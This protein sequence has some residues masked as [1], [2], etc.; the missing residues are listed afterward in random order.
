MVV[1][2]SYRFFCCNDHDGFYHTDLCLKQRLD[3][4]IEHILFDSCIMSHKVIK[5]HKM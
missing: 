1:I 2:Y 3:N 4:L 5:K